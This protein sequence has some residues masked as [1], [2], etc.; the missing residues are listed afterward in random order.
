MTSKSLD[1]PL[2]TNVD[3]VDL[4]PWV[5]LLQFSSEWDI[6][7]GLLRSILAA[8]AH[9]GAAHLQGYHLLLSVVNDP[10]IYSICSELLVLPIYW[11]I[12]ICLHLCC[13]ID[14]L[15][16]DRW[17]PWGLQCLSGQSHR[18]SRRTGPSGWRHVLLGTWFV[19]VQGGQIRCGPCRLA[20]YHTTYLPNHCYHS[21][22]SYGWC[23]T[24]WVIAVRKAQTCLQW[25]V[26]GRFTSHS[27][28]SSSS[29]SLSVPSFPCHFCSLTS[30]CTLD[31][32][33]L[34]IRFFIFFPG[35]TSPSSVTQTGSGYWSC[36]CKPYSF[37]YTALLLSVFDTPCFPHA[38]RS[39]V[40]SS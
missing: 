26:L 12:P 5:S 29:L 39:P 14:W 8:V 20:L 6:L 10:S 32:R 27:A 4:V 13:F 19:Q 31:S 2:S 23:T 25:S 36:S 18:W 28:L 15:C 16:L 1:H 17:I 37:A 11:N 22:V 24:V 21:H 9:P 40:P 3:L 33:C 34:L 7:H 30:S 38:P 35:I